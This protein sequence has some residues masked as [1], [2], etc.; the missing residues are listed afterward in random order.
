MAGR[1]GAKAKRGGERHARDRA[2][3]NAALWVILGLVVALCLYLGA[4]QVRAAACR[5][6]D[7]QVNTA[8]IQLVNQK[9]FPWM[10]P[11]AKADLRAPVAHLHKRSVFDRTLARDLHRSMRACPWV[12][13]VHYVRKRY[14]NRLS[15]RVAIR[16]PLARVEVPGSRAHVLVDAE[17]VRLPDSGYVKP[18][19]ADRLPI[20]RGVREPTPAVRGRFQSAEIRAAARMAAEL[21]NYDILPQIGITTVDVSNL[22]GRV[23]PR[24]QGLVLVTEKLTRILWGSPPGS[25][26]TAFEEAALKEKICMLAELKRRGPFDRYEVVDVRFSDD[27]SPYVRLRGGRRQ[28]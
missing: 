15:W 3:M 27:K 25:E 9:E 7:F 24:E 19:H 6:P 13:R 20:V 16:E 1:S 2:W 22:E 11:Q 8:N 4:A 23:D 5:I 14:P 12:V 17:G 26:Q 18:A 21:S 28:P 10:G